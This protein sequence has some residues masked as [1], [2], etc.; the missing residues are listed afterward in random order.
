MGGIRSK[1]LFYSLL[2]KAAVCYSDKNP[3]QLPWL[4]Y[5]DLVFVKDVECLLINSVG[6]QNR[7]K[8][9]TELCFD[10]QR[11]IAYHMSEWRPCCPDARDDFLSSGG[12]DTAHTRQS[13][14]LIKKDEL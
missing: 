8:T 4:T 2:F 9:S 12:R 10:Q 7:T 5:Q 13:F 3:L 14:G 6:T 11:T 1:G